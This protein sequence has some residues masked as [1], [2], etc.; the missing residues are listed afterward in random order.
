MSTSRATDPV[1]ELTRE[2]REVVQ[3]LLDRMNQIADRLETDT[4]VA[5][6]VLT[7]GITLWDEY[8]H[9]VH[10]ARLEHLAGQKSMLCGPG[11]KEVLEDHYRSRERMGRIRDLVRDYAADRRHARAALALALRSDT[12]V[13]TVWLRFEEEHPFGCLAQGLTPSDR[14]NVARQFLQDR[15][16]VDDLEKRIVR[17]LARPI[18]VAPDRF[19][20]R[21]HVA[22]CAARAAVRFARG[23]SGEL[24]LGPIPADWT[25]APA[26]TEPPA[27]GGPSPF[28]FYCPA[29]S[30]RA[31]T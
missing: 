22:S 23:G 28:A 16:A 6:P 8:L 27:E 18:G 15:E 3:P 19:E 1:E 11:L 4:N 30:A 17:F 14:E 26:S 31:R 13:D 12:Y 7:E 21:C 10:L 5:E 9:G 2:H 24:R 20:I 29:H 25:T